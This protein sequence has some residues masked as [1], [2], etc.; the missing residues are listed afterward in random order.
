MNIKSFKIQK[1][2]A[3]AGIDSR[4]KIEK[5]VSA[6]KVKINGKIAKIGQRV[7]YQ[8]NILFDNKEINFKDLEQKPRLLIYNKP[9]GE[10]VSKMDPKNRKNV[11]SSLP[12]L[13]NSKW[14]SVGRLDINTSGL[15]LFTNSGDLANE[16]MHPKNIYE[17]EYAVKISGKLSY[18]SITK[19]KKGIVLNDGSANFEYLNVIRIMKQN[20]WCRVTLMEGRNR[21]VRRM[22]DA[23][24]HSVIKLKRIRFGEFKLPKTLKKGEYIEIIT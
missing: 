17:R 21:L 10:I 12:K 22:F 4:R 24:N 6:G 20:S 8:D 9:V 3:Q 11:F 1:I 13:N 16:L 23:V 15:L 14:I 2:L 18:G 19:L 7:T 5:C